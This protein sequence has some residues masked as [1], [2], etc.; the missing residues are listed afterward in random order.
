MKNTCTPEIVHY[1]QN[2][3]QILHLCIPEFFWK[4]ATAW[5]EITWKDYST[6]TGFINRITYSIYQRWEYLLDLHH[7]D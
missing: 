4:T 6:E 2:T 5:V 7:L 1:F 3:R